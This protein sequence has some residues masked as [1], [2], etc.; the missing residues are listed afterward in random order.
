MYCWTDLDPKFPAV[1]WMMMPRGAHPFA[2]IRQI[3]RLRQPAF[4]TILTP[5]PL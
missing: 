4:S 3:P 5:A 1:W 2:E